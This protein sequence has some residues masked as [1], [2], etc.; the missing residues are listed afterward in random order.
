M[1]FKKKE[2][3]TAIETPAVENSKTYLKIY[4]VC[5]GNYVVDNGAPRTTIDKDGHPIF[6]PATTPK[7]VFLRQKQT[8]ELT[9]PEVIAAIRRSNDL[10]KDLIELDKNS[11][12]VKGTL[13]RLRSQVA[14]ALKLEKTTE[15]MQHQDKR[16]DIDPARDNPDEAL[17]QSDSEAGIAGL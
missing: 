9:D 4:V 14:D 17:K 6:F 13:P 12:P 11:Q 10:G 8:Y 15:R 5:G 16:A 3:G 2:P 7:H 1:V